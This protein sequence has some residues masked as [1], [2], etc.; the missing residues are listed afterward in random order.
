MFWG[1]SQTPMM[2]LYT[3]PKVNRPNTTQ[4]QYTSWEYPTQGGHPKTYVHKF[5]VATHWTVFEPDLS[6]LHSRKGR[7]GRIHE[8]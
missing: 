6:K 1:P 7:L 8:H 4:L 5:L 3:H 2:W